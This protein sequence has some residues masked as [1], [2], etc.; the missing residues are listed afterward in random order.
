MPAAEEL[1][2]YSALMPLYFPRSLEE[3]QAAIKKLPED[4]GKFGGKFLRCLNRMTNL[5]PS[6][7][8]RPRRAGD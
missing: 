2:V 3:E 1:A 7:R 6:R 5:S 8:Q 4:L